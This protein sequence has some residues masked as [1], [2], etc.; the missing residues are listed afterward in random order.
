MS[1]GGKRE[2][3][4]AIVNQSRNLLLMTWNYGADNQ[5]CEKK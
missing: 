5:L 4:G 1:V 3:M 2:I